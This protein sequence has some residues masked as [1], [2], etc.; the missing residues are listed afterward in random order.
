[1]LK[2]NARELIAVENIE[3]LSKN[4]AK[5]IEL[6]QRNYHNSPVANEIVAHLDAI[7]SS[8]IIEL[9]SNIENKIKIN[10]QH[11][12][13]CVEYIVKLEKLFDNLA[14]IVEKAKKT[15]TAINNKNIVNSPALNLLLDNLK[16]FREQDL[17]ILQN[18]TKR[19]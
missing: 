5:Q 7:E 4:I 18:L 9:A 3:K 2:N 14:T 12:Q 17:H 15:A 8:Q 13:E 6:N 16:I 1:M 19:E 11:N 10:Q